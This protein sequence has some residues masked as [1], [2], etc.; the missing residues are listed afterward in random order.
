MSPSS[1]SSSPR[2]S[3]ATQA[4]DYSATHRAHLDEIEKLRAKNEAM[5]EQ[6]AK[7]QSKLQS[8]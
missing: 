8:S 2:S 4:L 5:R 6:L 7:L 3:C 1:T